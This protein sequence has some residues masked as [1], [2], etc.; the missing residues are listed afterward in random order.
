M[1]TSIKTTSTGSVVLSFDNESGERETRLFFCPAEGGYIREAMDN[2]D[3]RQVC[4]SLD[5]MGVTLWAPRKDLLESVIRRE[6]ER[7]RAAEKREMTA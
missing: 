5:R 3:A 2:G 6:Y 4:E 1:K 7:M